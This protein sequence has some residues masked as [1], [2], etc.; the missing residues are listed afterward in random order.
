[1]FHAAIAESFLEIFTWE[2]LCR[3]QIPENWK[4]LKLF[5]PGKGKRKIDETL[6]RSSVLMAD[7][8]NRVLKCP[9]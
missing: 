6:V 5:K 1:M 8:S 3:V 7:T 2:V 4:K 9:F